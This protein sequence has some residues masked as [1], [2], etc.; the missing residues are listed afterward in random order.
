[1]DNQPVPHCG[2]NIVC[3][4]W[5]AY[6]RRWRDLSCFAITVIGGAL[7]SEWVKEFVSHAERVILHRELRSDIPA[8]SLNTRS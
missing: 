5:V 2:A 8:S 6:R 3:V 7:L 4:G 1:L